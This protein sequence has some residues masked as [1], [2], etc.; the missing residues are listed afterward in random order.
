VRRSILLA[1]LI[2]VAA[3]LASEPQSTSRALGVR[4][5]TYA[6]VIV[7]DG[8]RP[9]YFRLTAMPN[10]HWLQSQGVTYSQAFVGQLIANTPLARN[11]RDRRVPAPARGGGLWWTDPGRANLFDQPT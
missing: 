4:V 5:P 3:L 9:D 2:C 10:L 8:A 7:L 11:D 6:V 1:V